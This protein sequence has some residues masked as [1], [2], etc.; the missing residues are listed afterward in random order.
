M[1]TEPRRIHGNGTVG[2]MVVLDHVSMSP[3]EPFSHY[4]LPA[5]FT[6]TGSAREE[7]PGYH[8][9]YVMRDTGGNTVSTQGSIPSYLIEVDDWQKWRSNREDQTHSDQI[10]KIT[11]LRDRLELL[12]EI[13]MGQ[14]VRVIT[15]EQAVALGIKP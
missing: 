2:M 3:D 5:F 7:T 12:K 15:N 9:V 6:L 4:R 8:A 11:T 1:S 14:G 10:R 13:M